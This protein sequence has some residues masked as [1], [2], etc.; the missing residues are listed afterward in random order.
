MV[1]VVNSQRGKGTSADIPSANEEYFK[2]FVK[3]LVE[4]YD[5]DGINDYDPTIKVKYWQAGNEPF[6]RQWEENGGTIQGYIRF[7]EILSQ[8]ARESDP[9]QKI[10]LG[11]FALQTGKCCQI[12]YGC[13]SPEKQKPV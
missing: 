1:V 2:N 3:T 4:R 8:S 10:I 9:V 11:A 7:T 5:G 6:P 13:L 12:Q